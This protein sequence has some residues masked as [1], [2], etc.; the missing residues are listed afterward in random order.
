MGRFTFL[1]LS[2][3]MTNHSLLAHISR[4][5]SVSSVVGK[6]ISLVLTERRQNLS[7]LLLGGQ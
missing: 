6:M 3:H 5:M 7:S 2:V 1:Y 4:H